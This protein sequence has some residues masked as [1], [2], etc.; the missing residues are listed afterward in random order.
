MEKPVI[1]IRQADGSFYEIMDEAQT[2]RKRLVLSAARSD[3]HGVR[4]DLYRSVDG[5][6]ESADPLG[7][8]SLDDSGGAGYQDIEFRVDIGD[9]AQLDASATLPGQQPKTLSV[10]LSS[11]RGPRSDADILGDAGFAAAEVD[12]LDDSFSDE[13]TFDLDPEPMTLDLPDAEESGDSAEEVPRRSDAD[14]LDDADLAMAEVDNLDDFGWEEEAEAPD[15]ASSAKDSFDLGDLDAGF[16]EDPAPMSSPE[17]EAEPDEAW[18][19]ISLDD[20]EPM[21][22][23]DTGQ[24]IS[25]PTHTPV[26]TNAPAAKAPPAKAPAAKAK[27]APSQDDFQMDDMEPLELGDFDSD[28]S[29]LPDL[30]DGPSP[31]Q[32]SFPSSAD[33]FDNDFLPPPALT[34]NPIWEAERTSSKSKPVKAP[35]APKAPK[36]GKN[37]PQAPVS[38]DLGAGLDK[39]AL[40]LS[41][42]TLSL[43]V[44]LILVLLFLNMIKAPVPPVIQPEV[45]GW[46]PSAA[47]AN[48]TRQPSTSVVDFGADQRAA[49]EANTVVEVPVG[50]REA[51]I[52]LKLAPG[53]TAEDAARRFGSPA[54]I[55]GDQLFW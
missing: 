38:S 7:S 53:D 54:R 39:T 36:R 40:F 43:L 21:E 16:G 27:P 13:T 48:R 28:L 3:Q 19:K 12:T 2:G 44:L 29:D 49:F 6:L 22:F 5:T 1:G 24:E 35:K 14:I 18:E 26:L 31:A 8:I 30:G 11:F 4:I 46:N 17:P 50:L 15:L 10:D 55:Q 51:R 41:L 32:D 23:M 52:S 33:E 9:D 47:M 45:M 34:E 42:A 37:E 20:M 25:Q